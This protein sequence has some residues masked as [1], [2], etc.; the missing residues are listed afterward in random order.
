MADEEN[1]S[2]FLTKWVGKAKYDLSLEYV[3]NRRNRVDTRS[4]RDEV[5]ATQVE[6]AHTSTFT[7]VMRSREQMRT[8]VP[9]TE[10]A[11]ALAGRSMAPR[12]EDGDL[13]TYEER[14][15]AVSWLA[16]RKSEPACVCDQ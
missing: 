10:P 1:P 7:P 16:R 15:A 2:D 12:S 9:D 11:P 5:C 3:K 4:L 6:A 13:A 8:S 14:V